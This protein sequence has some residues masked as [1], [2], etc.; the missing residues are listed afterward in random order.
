MLTLLQQQTLSADE[1]VAVECRVGRPTMEVLLHTRPQTGLEGKFS[2]QYCMAAALL[3]KR[4]GLLTFSDEKV[5]R[6]A[7]QQLCERISMTLHPEAQRLGSDGEELPVTVSVSLQDSRRLTMQ[8]RYPKG[9]PA[10]PLSAVALQEKF[11]DCASGVLARQDIRRVS[12]LVQDLEQIE[13]IG[14]LMDVLIS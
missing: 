2:M 14:T 8:I 5:R 1:V 11:E 10:N 3:D 13:M 6:P 9:H 7:A 12:E 4:I